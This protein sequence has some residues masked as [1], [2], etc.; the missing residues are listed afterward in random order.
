MSLI[1]I[2]AVLDPVS[3]KFMLEI[4]H[5]HDAEQPFVTTS[6]RHQSKAAAENDVIAIIAAAASGATAES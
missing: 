6:P 5:P 1:R 2:E 3:N 4:Y